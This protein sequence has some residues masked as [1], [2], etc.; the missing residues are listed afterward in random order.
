MGT[1]DSNLVTALIEGVS[2]LQLLT[3]YQG[4]HMLVCRTENRSLANLLRR[5][6]RVAALPRRAYDLNEHRIHA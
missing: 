3:L 4:I 5:H 1:R 6:C 2:A